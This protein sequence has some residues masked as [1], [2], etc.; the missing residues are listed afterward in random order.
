M[1]KQEVKDLLSFLIL[2]EKKAFSQE[3]MFCFLQGKKP[4]IIYVWIKKQILYNY[5]LHLY[6]NNFGW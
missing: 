4:V 5:I 6:N 2:D 1:P 3:K